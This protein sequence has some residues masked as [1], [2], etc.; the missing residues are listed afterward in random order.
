MHNALITAVLSMTLNRSNSSFVMHSKIIPTS[1][2][3]FGPLKITRCLTKL[4]EK[5]DGKLRSNLYGETGKQPQVGTKTRNSPSPKHIKKTSPRERTVV[6]MYHKPPNVIT[7]HSDADHVSVSAIAG[8]SGS[9]RKTVYEDIY[10]M[11]GF[12][13]RKTLVAKSFEKATGIQSKLHAIGRLDADTTGLLLLTNDG[14]LVHR[15]TNPSAKEYSANGCV[16]IQKSL[17]VQKTYEAI[18]MGNHSLPS[19]IRKTHAF[20]S[21]PLLNLIH[22]GVCLPQKYG[23]QTRPVDKLSILSHPSRT[24]T[25]VSITISEGKN[26]QV[27][28][29]FHAI[30]SGVMKLHRKQVGR[31]DLRGLTSYCCSDEQRSLSELKEGEWRVLTDEEVKEGLGWNCRFIDVI[32]ERSGRRRK[33]RFRQRKIPSTKKSTAKRCGKG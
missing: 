3:A 8:Q 33:S 5:S 7:S 28:R 13:S 30:G 14:A 19:D 12:I 24:T 1:N 25:L 9:T 20:S 31:L 11:Q 10:S 4:N 6:I 27:R 23:G 17:P 32:P 26:R 15:I 18:I 2:F 22:D 16:E 21:Y 29:M